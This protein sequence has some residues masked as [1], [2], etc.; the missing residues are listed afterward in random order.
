MESRAFEW[1][2]LS[3]SRRRSRGLRKTPQWSAERR[4]GPRYG[5]AIP[6]AD[7][8][9]HAARQANGRGVPRPRISALRYPLLE[10]RRVRN[11]Q[12]GTTARRDAPRGNAPARLNKFTEKGRCRNCR[13]KHRRE[14]VR[15]D[16]FAEPV[17]GP[18]K[19]RTRWLAMTADVVIKQQM[20]SLRGARSA[21]KQSPPRGRASEARLLRGACHR[22][23]Q[24]P[25]PLARNDGSPRVRSMVATS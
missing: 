22:A 24:R 18:A 14:H 17:I 16:C 2:P 21:T 11:R 20:L 4:A 13:T 1:A 25:D 6:S 3:V 12:F 5:P 8:R 15:R 19:G 10:G 7:G 23:G 9:G